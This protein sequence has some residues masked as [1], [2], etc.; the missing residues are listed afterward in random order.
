MWSKDRIKNQ[1]SSDAKG[2]DVRE[3]GMKSTREFKKD[4]CDDHVKHT[5]SCKSVREGQ[6]HKPR[7]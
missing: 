2:S 1:A 3:V 4:R 5:A 6:V 7:R